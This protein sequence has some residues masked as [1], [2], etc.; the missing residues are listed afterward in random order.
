MGGL[1][2]WISLL[3]FSVLC[4]VESLSSFVPFLYLDLYVF[5]D[6]VLVS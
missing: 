3:R 6:D 4:T 5:R 1:K 2:C